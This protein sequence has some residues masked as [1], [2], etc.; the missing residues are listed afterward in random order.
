MITPHDMTLD[1]LRLALA[2]RLPGE[3]AFDGWSETALA[4]AA[5]TRTNAASMKM[6]TAS[7]KPTIAHTICTMNALPIFWSA[8]I[9]CI[10][11]L[12]CVVTTAL[13]EPPAPMN[14]MPT[15]I[16]TI[17]AGRFVAYFAS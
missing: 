7:T 13:S 1:E 5:A 3:A 4:A 11:S 15:T 17:P 6:R 10:R 9:M 12:P 14:V 16:A 2:E 8:C